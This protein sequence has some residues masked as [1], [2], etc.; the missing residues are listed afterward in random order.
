[1]K[2]ARFP[3]LGVAVGLLMVG[4]LSGGCNGLSSAPTG[5]NDGG[6]D[7]AKLDG[8]RPAEVNPVSDGSSLPVEAGG[9]LPE[10]NSP[11]VDATAGLDPVGGMD[12]GGGPANDVSPTLEDASAFDGTGGATDVPPTSEDALLVD[13]G[14]M[15][16]T[17][18]PVFIDTATG[19]DG[20]PLSV[21]TVSDVIDS[22]LPSDTVNRD[23]PP[24]ITGSVLLVNA[25]A[26]KTVCSGW[27][28]AIGAPAQG[29]TAP[30]TY[31]WAANPT[32]SD[33]I[34]SPTAAQP[35]VTPDATTT[36]TVTVTDSTGAIAVDAV[37]VTVQTGLANLPETLS[38]DPSTPTT[39]GMPGQTGATYA[40][41]CDR[42]AC[43]ISNPAV[44]QP[45]VSPSLSTMYTLT[46]TSAEGCT[47]TD[48]TTVWVNLP[49]TTIP[50]DQA[51]NYPAE[52][53][54]Y[55][56]FGANVLTSS[57][58][59]TSVTL[60]ESV[61]GTPVTFTTDYNSSQRILTIAPTGT[62][63]RASIGAYTLTLASG[64]SG[65]VS[66]DTLRPQVLAQDL[67][68]NLDLTSTADN[69][70]P[71]IISRTPASNAYG[72]ATNA[73]VSVTFSETLDPT[74][75][76]ATNFTVTSGMTSV[77]GTLTYDPKTSTIVFS[78]TARLAGLT[79]YT[80][81]LS[82]IQDLSGNTA[83]TSSWYF[84]TAMASDTTAPT[85]TAVTPTSGTTGVSTNAMIIIT[86]SE[87]M[88]D[89][90]LTDIRLNAGTTLIAGSVV[91][92]A[93]TEQATFTPTAPLTSQTLYTLTVTGVKDLAGNAM[94][95]PFTSTFTTANT[96]FADS[97]ESGT[98]NW[99]LST[100]WGLTTDTYQSPNH[101]LTDSPSG[102]Y[103]TSANTS[104]TS[105]PI[106]VTGLTS[107]S[108]GYWL[109]GQTQ[110]LYDFL[111][112]EYSTNGTT[113]NTVTTW[114]GT[115]AATV[116]THTISLPAGAT[117]LQIR[118][119]LTS[120]TGVQ[121]DGVYIDDVIVQ[122][123]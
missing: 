79:T 59:A 91:Y 53:A 32:C 115:M 68:V 104:A 55:V 107:V 17:D 66:A 40:W 72:V 76:T 83:T 43:A 101:S 7:L 8:V 44:A 36:F 23:L 96:L 3:G 88:D 99:T 34:S 73:T 16:Q 39:L 105:D 123:N 14:S 98:T 37:K 10:V 67:V 38:A 116:H 15:G 103:S 5:S 52:A 19:D 112:V 21:D 4:L 71:T 114:S 85:V 121:Y 81:R 54:L 70:R 117:S 61:S 86:F 49:A 58:N 48:S 64:A 26:D 63:Y 100:P 74:S 11:D 95:A 119:R 94:A 13:T 69:T 102:N 50:A 106:D 90:S 1:M 108:L 60:R 46:A 27:P 93:G 89:S 122:T 51:T 75:V 111:R 22:R 92:D 33:C 28:T 80:V 97:F 42:P 120:N 25:G 12:G 30:Y 41:T 113:W 18:L 78:P 20:K 24:D 109:S 45:S 35:T 65:I 62:N 57:I 9:Q 47:S 29:G 82:G 56:L 6:R 2:I 87:A 118:F 84:T 110:S 77:V 31:A